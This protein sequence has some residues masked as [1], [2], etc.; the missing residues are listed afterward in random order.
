MFFF[1]KNESNDKHIKQLSD[2]YKNIPC[3]NAAI[4]NGNA[5]KCPGN[6]LR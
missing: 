6:H 3:S 5:G 2:E 1:V 4:C